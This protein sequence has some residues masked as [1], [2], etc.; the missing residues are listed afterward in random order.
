MAQGHPKEK[1]V[2]RVF[3][4]IFDKLR[5]TED[6]PSFLDD[7]KLAARG[8]VEAR[9]RVDALTYV[10]VLFIGLGIEPRAWQRRHRHLVVLE[11][12]GRRAQQLFEAGNTSG[13]VAFMTDHPLLR[14]LLWPEALEALRGAPNLNALSPLTAAMSLDAHLGWLAAWDLD[15]SE[16]RELAAPQFACLLPSPTG[17]GRN[18][19]SL[20]FDELKR[21]LGVSSVSAMLDECSGVPKVEIG[22]LYR[23]SAG[24]N[25]PDPDTLTSLMEAH[26]QLD[27]RDMLY[28]QFSAA[29]LVNLLGYLGQSL[30][31]ITR[32]NGEPPALWPWPAY[33]FGHPDFESWA[34][35]RYPYW[36]AYHRE[37]GA[38][39]AELAKAAQG[40]SNQ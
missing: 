33:P 23:W 34:A 5:A 7:L 36:L 20:L 4:E 14:A 28:R 37:N 24:K 39:L 21:R 25:F 2:V 12:A 40:T 16:D 27:S 15:D 35:A 18:P 32:E 17:L 1:L 30:S 8:C 13:A 29:K 26:G 31:A 3:D 22:T 10:E 11:R 6:A 38:V 9:Q 19:T